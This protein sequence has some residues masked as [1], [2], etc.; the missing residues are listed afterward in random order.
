MTDRELVVRMLCDSMVATY[1]GD[2]ESFQIEYPHP[3]LYPLGAH[4]ADEQARWL[5]GGEM[6]ILLGREFA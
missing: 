3:A 2:E 5:N 4:F 6:P 1:V